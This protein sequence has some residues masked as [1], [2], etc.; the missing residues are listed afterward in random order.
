M[1]YQ[2]HIHTFQRQEVFLES[3]QGTMSSPV[4]HEL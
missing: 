4:K 3:R 1:G 2:Y